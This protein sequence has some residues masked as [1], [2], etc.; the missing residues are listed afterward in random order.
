M[1]VIKRT[2]SGPATA[3][4]RAAKPSKP[5]RISEDAGQGDVRLTGEAQRSRTEA[6]LDGAPGGYHCGPD[7]RGPRRDP[8]RLAPAPL[9]SVRQSM[10]EIVPI[11]DLKPDPLNTRKH[12]EYQ[13]ELLTSSILKFGFHGTLGIDENNQ[14]VFGHGS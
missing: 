9:P 10:I 7:H 12:S 4:A 8:S 11:N 2:K 6:V 3:R 1:I 14:I 13:I 5:K